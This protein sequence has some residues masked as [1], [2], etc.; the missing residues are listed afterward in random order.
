MAGGAAIGLAVAVWAPEI[1]AAA[2]PMLSAVRDDAGVIGMGIDSD[3]ERDL[4]LETSSDLEGWEPMASVSAHLAAQVDRL[5]DDRV[6]RESEGFYRVRSEPATA[7]NRPNILFIYTDDQAPWAVGAAG[8]PYARTPNMDRLFAEGATLRNAFTTTPVCSPSR[9]SL[10]A[11]RYGTELGVTEW[12]HP[13]AEADLGLDPATVTWP[14][15]LQSA[16]YATG[17]VGK[18]HLGLPDIYHPTRTGYDYFMGFRGGGNSPEDPSLEEDGVTRTFSGY[19]PDILTDHALE[20]IE[21]NRDRP[22]LMS[23][24]FRAPHTAWQPVEPGIWLRFR[25]LD[26]DVPN[27]DYPNLDIPRVKRMTREYLASIA[28]VDVNIGRLL[29]RLDALQ[30]TH[31]TVVIFTSDHGYNMGHNGIWHKGNGHWVLTQ[32]PPATPNIPSGQR[33]NMYDNSIRV[34]AAI[35]WPGVVRPGLVVEESLTNLDWFPTLLAIAGVEIPEGLL[36]R[37]RN[38]LPLLFGR[39][40]EGW[41]NDVYAEYSTHHQSHTHM[42]MYRTPKWKLIRDFLN[43]W[44]DELYNLEE[45]PEEHFN[46][47]D[48]DDPEVRSVIDELHGKIVAKMEEINDPILALLQ[49]ETP[50]ELLEAAA[51]GLLNGVVLTFSEKLDF[52]SAEKPENYQIDGIDG[53]LEVLGASVLGDGD[54]VSLVTG[55][56]TEGA[57]YIVQV[58]GVRDASYQAN[59]LE[60]GVQAEFVATKLDA[61]GLIMETYENISGTSL[62]NLTTHPKFPDH[63]DKVTLA[64]EFETPTNSNDNYGARLRGFIAPEVSGNYVFYI[65]SDD[66]AELYLGTNEDPESIRLIAEDPQWHRPRTWISEERRNRVDIGTPFERWNNVSRPIPLEAGRQYAVEARMKDGAGGDNLA[67][68]WRRAEAPPPENGDPPISG[69]FLIPAVVD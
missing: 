58:T 4:I 9:A 47:I 42:R 68:T 30:L 22:F 11:S 10:M 48:S 69:E 59:P 27:P 38:F 55:P 17:L 64:T 37:G 66:A 25:N 33:P 21:A 54:R 5:M 8:H 16:G 1:L 7:Q 12:L 43:P 53:G 19:T 44:R 18:W 36:V 65:C 2:P 6:T 49:D 45:D 35:R 24:H 50:P 34:P 32:N 15:L 60:A 63:P 28:S 14:E 3:P 41:D 40:I 29:D 13:T 56:Q 20:F 51:N 23:L 31:R 61:G 62:A 46:L 57:T 67:V 39:K 26:P 52:E